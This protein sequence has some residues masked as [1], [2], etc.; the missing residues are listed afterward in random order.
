MELNNDPFQEFDGSVVTGS[1]KPAAP[2]PSY[3]NPFHEFG[4]KPLTDNPDTTKSDPFEQFG[5]QKSPAVSTAQDATKL[6]TPLIKPNPINQPGVPIVKRDDFDSN[7]LGDMLVKQHANYAGHGK[8]TDLYRY[9]S[10]QPLQNNILS[11]STVKPTNAKDADARYVS[12]DDPDF[13][14]QVLDNYKRVSTG[15]MVTTTQKGLS[16]D[17]TQEQKTGPDTYNVSAYH[18]KG[19]SALGHYTVSKGSDEKGNYISY[20]DKF[21]TNYGAQGIGA[22]KPFEVYGRVYYDPKTNQIIPDKN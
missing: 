13:K 14:Q 11:I 10:G 22:L 20:Y 18:Q 21:N 7:W 12:I 8:L 9:F 2:I 19:G 4:G 1:P 15:G 3:V 5:G 16:D 6:V 17:Y